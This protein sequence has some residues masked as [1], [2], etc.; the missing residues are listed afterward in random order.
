MKYKLPQGT[1]IPKKRSKFK[2]TDLQKQIWSECYDPINGPLFFAEH[3]CYVKKNG[4]VPYIPYEYQREMLFNMHNYMSTISLWSRQNGKTTTSGVYLLWYA[5]AYPY[6]DILITS[7]TETSANEI[8]SNIKLLYENCPDFLKVPIKTMNESTIKF[9]NNSRIFSRP[10]TLKAPRGLSPAYIYC[11]EFAFVGQG[12]SEQKSREKQE[13][14]FAAISPSLSTSKGKLAITSTPIS[15]TDLFYRL[16]SGAIT[17]LDDQGI[18]IPKDYMLK[19]NGE[20]YQDFHLFKSED[21]AKDYIQSLNTTNTV[22]IVIRSPIGNNGFQSQLVKWDS[23][24]EK[25]EEWKN[26]ELKRVGLE[27][28]ERE[29]N[30]LSGD[31]AVTILDE[32]GREIRTSLQ[33]LYDY[34]L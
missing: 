21:D 1:G 23:H 26:A 30:C 22:D 32:Q 11:D 31:G 7:F 5:M 29:Y 19:I 16:W 6:K 34:Y 12:E 8:L 27:R 4:L 14:F 25:T 17:K 2:L 18:D 10:T 15:E 9:A 13:E 28:F 3:C 20:L 24:P 33:I